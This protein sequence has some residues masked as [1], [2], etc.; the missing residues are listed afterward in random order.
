[1]K[2]LSANTLL[3]LILGVPVALALVPSSGWKLPDARPSLQSR[4]LQVGEVLGQ[5]L[6]APVIL[7]GM[8]AAVMVFKEN[9]KF[10]EVDPVY[11]ASKPGETA[12]PDPKP[13]S[14]PLETKVVPE[15]VVEQLET[16]MDDATD[17]VEEA[18]LGSTA[19]TTVAAAPMEE[20]F[21]NNPPATPKGFTPTPPEKTLN[22][23]VKE[24]GNTLEKN[25][26]VE[27]TVA[28]RKLAQ[29]QIEP[30]EPTMAD[31][32]PKSA[33]EAETLTP[34]VKTGTPSANKSKRR[35]AMRLIK[36]VVAPWRKWKNI[37]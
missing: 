28:S 36:K 25:R 4:N 13:V 2:F 16:A 34:K 24:V 20:K 29:Q 1:M 6:T 30:A 21:E 23:L 11:Q 33:L 37:Q 27:R 8:Y 19:T 3:C 9:A 15:K 5:A 35:T 10:N 31:D 26:A 32:T 18:F 7:G 17:A 22:D 14:P 12:S